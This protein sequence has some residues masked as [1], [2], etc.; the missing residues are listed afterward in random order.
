MQQ[1]LLPLEQ[2]ENIYIQPRLIE[3]KTK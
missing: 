3:R 1:V 2:R